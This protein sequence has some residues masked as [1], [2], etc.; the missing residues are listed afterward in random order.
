M[1]EITAT[2]A[3]RT[4]SAL[5]DEVEQGGS[6][7][8]TRGGRQIARVVPLLEPSGDALLDL[9][10]RRAGPSSGMD[11]AFAERVADV[12]TSTR[13]DLDVDPWQD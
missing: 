6:A 2:E 4:F 1:R 11:D 7:T 13:T 10:D 9:L 5:L 8:I 3:S 12:R